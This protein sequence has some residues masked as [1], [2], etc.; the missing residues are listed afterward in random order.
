MRTMLNIKPFLNFAI[1]LLKIL[2]KSTV[3]REISP[4]VKFSIAVTREFQPGAKRIFFYF[5]SP[6]AENIF[7]KICG[8]FYKN[9]LQKKT[10]L[11]DYIKIMMIS[12]TTEVRCLILK[13]F[14]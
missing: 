8:I 4:G 5:I 10:R 13:R 11:Q 1:T 9:I 14:K 7:S 2:S 6:W 12:P 3:T